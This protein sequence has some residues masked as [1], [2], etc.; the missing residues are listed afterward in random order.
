L[1]N[2]LGALADGI[3]SGQ[4]PV[5]RCT[6]FIIHDPKKRTITAPCFAERV[7][8]HAIM[9]VCEPVFERLLIDDTYACRRGKGRIAALHRAMDFSARY[10]V[11]LKLDMRSYF[12]SISHEL[13]HQQLKRRFKDRRLLQLFDR[14]SD[15][16]ET[17][18][19]CGLPIGSLTSQHFANF[20]LA[21][22]DRF[23]KEE[24]GSRGYVRYMDDCVIWST[25]ASQLRRILA[26]CEEFLVRDLRL[27]INRDPLIRS[28]RNGFEFLGCRVF[29]THLQLNHRSRQRFRRRLRN[30][31]EAFVRGL[32]S[33]RALQARATALCAFA[34][35]GGT[36]S[37]KFRTRV[38]QQMPVSGQ[39]LEPGEPGRE[40]EQQGRELSVG[41]P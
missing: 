21:G 31:E 1:E 33:E 30:L 22:F 5:G 24:L 9:N 14:I 37:W 16:Y 25:S 26:R 23:V 10:P 36:K 41:E 2:N 11:I 19:G 4:Y 20:Y 7:L 17:N 18:P 13:L 32:I 3:W 15:G 8:H 6:Q 39:R 38:I 29:P 40:L 12:D 28:T 27:H 35:A 34:T